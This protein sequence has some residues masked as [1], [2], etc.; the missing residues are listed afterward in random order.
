MSKLE[1]IFIKGF[2]RL[3]HTELEMRDLIVMIGANGSG[4]TSFLDVLSILAA[5]ARGNLHDTLQIKGGLNEI[6]TRARELYMRLPN[7]S[8]VVRKKSDEKWKM[9]GYVGISVS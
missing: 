3:E 4:K 6:L 2:R 7:A 1:N 9:S 8:T 5:S